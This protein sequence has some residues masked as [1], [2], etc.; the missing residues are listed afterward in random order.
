MKG[1][2]RQGELDEN[3][4][5]K[6][7]FG[8]FIQDL[9]NISKSNGF[10]IQSCAEPIEMDQ[11][12][13]SHGKC[14]DDNYIAKVFDLVVMHK[15]DTGQRKE[16]GCVKSVDIGVYDTCLHGCQYCYA[17]K[18]H[19]TAKKNYNAHDPNSPSILGW[20]DAEPPKADPQEKLF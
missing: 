16:C 12:G 18:Q 14:I 11:Y 2:N 15:K 10:E 20:Y 7:E 17:T 13:V 3:P 5:D 19:E 8:T 9:A 4:E 1:Y 6:I